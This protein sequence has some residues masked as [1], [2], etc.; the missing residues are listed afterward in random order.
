MQSVIGVFSSVTSARQAVE[1]LMDYGMSERSIIFLTRESDENAPIPSMSAEDIHKIPTTD[2]ERDGMGKAVG[3]VVGGAV[4]SGAG[5]AGGA[6]IASLLVPGVGPILAAGVG[7]AAV[8]GLGGLV[9]GAKAGDVA[10]PSTNA[11]MAPLRL[12][13]FRASIASASALVT[14]SSPFQVCCTEAGAL[15]NE[16]DFEGDENAI[17]D[18]KYS[19]SPKVT[20]WF[21]HHESAFL[22]P[23]DAAHFEQDQ[24]NRK[25][26]DPDFKSCTSFIATVGEQR[27]GFNPG[28]RRRADPL[29][30]HRRRCHVRRRPHGGRDEGAGHETHHGD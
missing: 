3:A 1:G 11:S 7:A 6:A 25:F 4:G 22:T 13:C 20:W 10:E 16:N 12:R 29:D 5:M 14:R 24:S 9:A 19:S 15:F 8:L 27:F 2:A 21:D 26:Y 18:F 30:R 17:V 23:E 28:A